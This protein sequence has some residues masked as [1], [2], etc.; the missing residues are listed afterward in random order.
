MMAVPRRM[1]AWLRQIGA[2]P[3][4]PASAGASGA[5]SRTPRAGALVLAS[6]GVLLL[7]LIPSSAGIAAPPSPVPSAILPGP[8]TQLVFGTPPSDTL[9]GATIRAVTVQVED[10]FGILVTSD[11]SG[12]TLAIATNPASGTL[13]GTLTVSAIG[14]VATFSDLSIDSLGTGYTLI[15]TD[16]VLVSA[17]SQFFNIVLVLPT[18]SP[19]PTAS[20]LYSPPPTAAPSPTTPPSCTGAIPSPAP[21]GPGPA[22]QLVFGVQ[23]SDTLPGATISPAVTVQVEDQFCNLVTSDMSTVS[24]ALGTGSPGGTLNG[25]FTVSAIGGVATFGDLSIANPGI[26]FYSIV[27]AD[28]SLT[29]ATSQPFSILTSVQV[30][31]PQGTS[32]QVTPVNANGPSPVSLT[33]N[34]VD[35]AGT[36]TVTTS[37]TDPAQP[38]S[39]YQAALYVDLVTTAAYTPPITVCVSYAGITPAPTDLLHFDSTLS[40]PAWVTIPITSN[41]NQVICGITNSLSPFAAVTRTPLT[42]TAVNQAK[43]YGAALPAFTAAYAGFLTGDTPSVLGGTLAFS[44]AAT[45]ASQVGTYLIIPSGLTSSGYAITYV[46]GTLTVTKAPLSVTAPSPSRAYGAANPSLSP[47]YSGFATGDTAASLAAQPTCSTTATIASPVGTYPVTCSGGVSSN[48]SFAYVAGTLR[49]AIPDRYVTPLNTTLT[50]TAPGI[51]ALSG[52]SASAITI[53][54]AP[55]GSLTVQ[56]TG[57]FKYVPKGGFSGTDTFAFRAT[58]NGTLAPAVTVTIYVLGKGMNCASCNLSGLSANGLALTGSNLS[59]ANLTG[60]SLVG[61]NLSG[62]NLSAVVAPG[63]NLSSATLTG[64]NLSA[65]AMS[66]ATLVGAN[67]TGANVTKANLSSATLNSATLIG[68]NLSAATMPGATLVSAN[69]TGANVSQANLANANLTSANFVGANLSYANLK[70]ANITGANF[71]GANV[72]G[73]IWR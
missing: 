65:A 54:K 29:P 43:A 68:A 16:G 44:T 25:T 18:P 52:G 13:S 22:T 60:A 27:A 5:Q 62:A 57:A 63:V 40:P 50:V 35:I 48:Y 42:V 53:T 67:L 49:I 64:A 38:L 8:A 26:G 73:V 11:T 9:P 28:G 3:V 45:A 21:S 71:T 69:L 72:A 33:F 56:A 10:Q 36:T 4:P 12:V 61:A 19:V 15:A 17:T 41:V 32:V 30:A 24:L 39:G 23:P 70:G 58:V 59:G 47:A 6:V 55:Q 51:L 46:A 31:T 1:V 7:L 20:L 37:T 34:T 66:G 14:G 2:P